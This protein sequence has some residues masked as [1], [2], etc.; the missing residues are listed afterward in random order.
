MT[1]QAK[2]VLRLNPETRK[3]LDVIQRLPDTGY[4]AYA[5][6]Y[7][8]AALHSP[9][10][11]SEMQGEELEVQIRYILSNL[12]YWKGYEAQAAKSTLREFAGIRSK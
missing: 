9:I 3:A 4:N 10:T 2:P 12:Q 6:V 8:R 7:A 5:K 11:G 1:G